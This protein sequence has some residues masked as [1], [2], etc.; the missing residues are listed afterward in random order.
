MKSILEKSM[1]AIKKGVDPEKVKQINE[2]AILG[3]QAGFPKDVIE[4]GAIQSL[5]DLIVFKT[6]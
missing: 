3:L 1:I 6:E 2:L 4:K 5:S